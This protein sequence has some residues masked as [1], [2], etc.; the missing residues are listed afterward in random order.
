MSSALPTNSPSS[1]PSAAGNVRR[2]VRRVVR[3]GLIA[4]AV[5]V[6]LAL[7]FVRWPGKIHQW[8]QPAGIHYG[9]FDPYFVAVYEVSPVL[10]PWPRYEVF[11][12][13]PTSPDYGHLTEYGFHNAAW[14]SDYFD[15]CTVD[16]TP[17]GITLT[18]PS[19]HRL[20][21]P[22]KSFIGGR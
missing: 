1:P 16:W 9:S 17:D 11:V 19:G 12:S 15:R 10:A 5:M 4:A 2:L 3:W 8:D 13:K 20:F 6:V 22:K 21:I 7:S 14:E 18:E